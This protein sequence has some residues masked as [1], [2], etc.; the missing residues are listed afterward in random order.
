LTTKLFPKINKKQLE[1]FSCYNPPKPLQ[2]KFATIV[3]QVEESKE[4]YQKS[5]DELRD[6]FGSLSQRAFK[7]ELDNAIAFIG[8][9]KISN[10]GKKSL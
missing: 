2:D 7:G 1:K 3:H 10:S 6:L 9:G 5:L 8:N 4:K